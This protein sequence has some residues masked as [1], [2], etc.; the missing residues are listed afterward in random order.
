MTNFKV[1]DN[2]MNFLNK[3]EVSVIENFL[4]ITLLDKVHEYVTKNFHEFCWRPNAG[5]WDPGLTLGSSAIMVMGIDELKE[6]L[7]EICLDILGIDKKLMLSV[8]HP[9]FYDAPIGSYVNWHS[10]EVPLSISVY[11]NELWKREWGGLFLYEKDEAIHGVIPKFNRAVIS[12][13]GVPHA[14]TTINPVADNH[15]Y[16]IQL[17]FTNKGNNE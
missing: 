5:V 17:F 4:P 9:M 11:L 16:S 3:G 8:P 12:G 6:E 14:V 2:K 15:R 10:E 13:P 1:V 7:S